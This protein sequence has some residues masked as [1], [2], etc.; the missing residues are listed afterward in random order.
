VALTPFR[1]IAAFVAG[2]LIVA[3]AL[4]TTPTPSPGTV[5]LERT[6]A[7]RE[8]L[9]G[10]HASSAGSM[11]AVAR[12]M[13]STRAVAAR[14]PMAPIRVFRDPAIPAEALPSLDLLAQR[15]TRDIGAKPRVSVDVFFAYDTAQ[16]I[17]GA[18]T[19]RW[20]LTLVYVLP[21]R[22]SER[23][24]VI[25]P[26][27]KY[28]KL[29]RLVVGF[30]RTEI[31]AHQLLGP[32]A[33]YAAFGMPGARVDRWLRERGW[34]LAG[35]GAWTRSAEPVDIPALFQGPPPPQPLL[36]MRVSAEGVVCAVGQVGLCER[37][38]VTPRPGGLST[39]WNG[40]ALIGHSW[41][42]STAEYGF[43]FG[44]AAFGRRENRML[45]DMVRTLGPDRFA[46]FWTSSEPVPVA[47][48]KAAGIPLGQWTAN[49]AVEQ[50]GPVTRGPGVGAS[51]LMVSALVALLAVFIAVRISAN[52]Q[53]A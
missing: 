35:D 52:R 53:F 13:D 49:W 9:S 45:T 17:R 1:W 46:R 22:A 4:L 31:F 25:M 40:K 5:D 32:C 18:S 10:E 3:V 15:S 50:Y 47:F 34:A 11:L 48:E 24:S 2:C 26:F 12:L 14:A 51:S 28:P 20:G 38:V 37:E 16:T 23:C 36:N 33:Y 29:R 8:Q 30:F 43:V 7:S 6:L 39:V 21:S 19:S 42:Q 27:P 41:S 44:R